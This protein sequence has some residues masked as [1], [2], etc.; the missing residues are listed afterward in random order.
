MSS[1]AELA[2]II[3]DLEARIEQLDRRLNNLV[4]EARVTEVD[5]DKPAVKVE[6]HGL[7]SDW[8][9]LTS[10]AGTGRLWSPPAVGE[11]GLF[12]SPSGEP[13]QGVFLRGGYCDAFTPPSSD[14]DAEVFA[15]GELTITRHKDHYEAKLGDDI[16]VEIT[17]D[18][19]RAKKGKARFVACDK[20]AKIR[21]GAAWVFVTEE[22]APGV[23]VSHAPIIMDDNRPEL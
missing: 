11:R 22:P 16:K 14:L 12:L 20:Q 2:Q 9:P 17:K 6:A 21:N 10:P 1:A 8:S 23:F 7:N 15:I 3:L 5:K 19:V 4:R 13:G 18:Y